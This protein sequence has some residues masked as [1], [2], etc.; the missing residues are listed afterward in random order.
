MKYSDLSIRQWQLIHKSHEQTDPIMQLVERVEALENRTDVIKWEIKDIIKK[1][2]SYPVFDDRQLIA[3][4]T[5]RIKVEGKVYKVAGEVSGMR[6][7]Q[8]IDYIEAT[9]QGTIQ[10]LHFILAILLTKRKGRFFG[11]WEKVPPEEILV[12]AQKILN[13]V[14]IGV[15][16]PITFFCSI[17]RKSYTELP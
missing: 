2:R 8:L 12:L 1:E 4:P 6:A 13:E 10:N 17:V 15:A 5:N 11:L 14:T 3:I 9:K 7:E 16:Y